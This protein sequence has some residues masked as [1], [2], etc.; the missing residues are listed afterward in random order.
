MAPTSA[1]LTDVSPP[2]VRTVQSA[3]ISLAWRALAPALAL[4][5]G[6]AALFGAYIA[7]DA[8]ISLAYARNLAAGHGPVLYPGAEAVEGFSNPAWTLLLALGAALGLDFG[9]GIPLL[10]TL[11]LLLGGSGLLLTALVARRAYPDDDPSLLWIAPAILAVWTPYVFWSGAGLENALYAFLLLLAVLLQL[12]EVQG[13][14]MGWWSAAALAGVALTR[15]EGC[16]FFLVFLAHRLVAARE[17][18]RLAAWTATFVI[19]CAG[20][21]ALRFTVFGDWLPNT[22]YAKVLDRDVGALW[23]YVSAPDD[24]GRKYLL[25]FMLPNL[26]VVGAAAAGWLHHQYWRTHLLFAGIAGGTFAYALYVG[27]DFWPAHRFLT[28]ALPLLA[29]SA[30]HGVSRLPLR[31]PHTRWIAAALVGLVAWQSARP[32]LDLRARHHADT[33]ISLQGRLEQGRE[34]R[35]LAASLGIEDPLYADPDIGGPAVAGLRVLDLGGLTDVHIARFRYYPPFFRDY[36]FKERRP[37]FVRTHASWT[38]TSRITEYPEFHE[39]YVALHSRRDARGLHGEFVRRDLLL[40]G[41]RDDREPTP[42][43]FRQAMA[44]RHA[45][46]MRE[47]AREQEG[48]IRYYAERRLFRRLLYA[49]RTHEAAGTLP[50]SPDLLE[51]LYYGLLAAGDRDAAERVRAAARIP[52]PAPAVLS[53]GRDAVLALVAHR[54]VR[55]DMEPSRLQLFFEVLRAP[56]EDY[57]LWLHLYPA[58]P[59]G[60]R[61]ITS[62]YAPRDGTSS[63]QVGMIATVEKPL[64]VD[65]GEYEIRAGLWEPRSQA[66][67]CRAPAGDPCYLLLGSHRLAR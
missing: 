22:Y 13:A 59:P 30:Q 54:V 27:G 45:R 57:H 34:I 35:A 15:P 24:P 28:P 50:S 67:L 48:W 63:W 1:I 55:R 41:G 47:D 18:W 36:V 6:H 25:A 38:R 52:A 62:N 33:L 14:S 65:P 43:S 64:Y 58:Q 29:L 26:V 32:S 3:A 5:A 4:Y 39:Q 2:P 66:P 40:G 16:A 20:Y 21:L 49:F 42:P 60:S 9:D 44:D 37:H 8:G 51:D 53:R 56:R 7:D 23:H 31:I 46:T 17:R 19:I 61:R 11:G 12:R 10:K